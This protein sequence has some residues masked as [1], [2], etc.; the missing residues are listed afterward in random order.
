MARIPGRP[1]PN[2]TDMPGING[3]MPAQPAPAPIGDTGGKLTK[4]AKAPPTPVPQI[5]K[6]KVAALPRS[7]AVRP[8]RVGVRKGRTI[9]LSRKS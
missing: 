6:A 7:P 8:A 3:P 9:N 5:Q 1:R 4:F 2:I